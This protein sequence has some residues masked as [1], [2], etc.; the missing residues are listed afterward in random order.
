MTRPS[1]VVQPLLYPLPHISANIFFLILLLNMITIM[2]TI[3][4]HVSSE[5]VIV[6]A[7]IAIPASL[8]SL[9]TGVA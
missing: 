1:E 9:T 7:F 3:M 5:S 2:T 4:I 6:A 8:L